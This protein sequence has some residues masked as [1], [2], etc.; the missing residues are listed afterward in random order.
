MEGT[1]KRYIV[2]MGSFAG[3]PCW[4]VDF[5]VPEEGMKNHDELLTE[6]L[7]SRVHHVMVRG[8]L[9]VKPDIKDFLAG[10]G[11][12]GKSI[13]FVTDSSEDVGPIRMVRNM[14]L[15]IL[16]EVPNA[17]ENYIH[18][19]LFAMLQQADEVE[20]SINSLEKYEAAKN[21]LKGRTITQPTILFNISSAENKKEI[22]DQYLL[23][24]DTFVFNS[25]M[26]HP[27]KL[28]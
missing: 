19:N 1:I 21:F 12:K 5:V 28:S 24:S 17:A 20:F 4:F 14:K 2:P 18:P 27:L 25:K 15:L 9:S 11:I 13:T 22:S 8:N 7:N 16:A 3:V 26:V 23:D 6:I 10:L